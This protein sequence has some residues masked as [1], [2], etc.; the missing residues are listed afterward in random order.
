MFAFF[1][2]DRWYFNC[3]HLSPFLCLS[4]TFP[5]SQFA[6]YVWAPV[7]QLTENGVSYLRFVQH[8]KNY[9][10]AHNLDN[11]PDSRSR[12]AAAHFRG[13]PEAALCSAPR[14]MH[15]WCLF[16][17]EA[18]SGCAEHIKLDRTCM[19]RK[20]CSIWSIFHIFKTDKDK[21]N[22]SRSTKKKHLKNSK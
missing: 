17:T 6:I 16:L 20:M 19:E 13:L 11:V 10:C 9:L 8:L 1:F 2:L 18:P 21:L 4:S 22:L 5:L 14:R 3:P 7:M 12:H 15:A